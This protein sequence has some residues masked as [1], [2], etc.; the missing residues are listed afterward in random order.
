MT[1]AAALARARKAGV[2][3]VVDGDRVRLRSG[4]VLPAA[5]LEELRQHRSEIRELLKRERL[6]DRGKAGKPDRH[7]RQCGAPPSA[8]EIGGFSPAGWHC[9]RCL[10]NAGMQP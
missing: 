3:F 1:A 10:T 8:L 7:C 5:L 2:E 6:A 4:D 9:D